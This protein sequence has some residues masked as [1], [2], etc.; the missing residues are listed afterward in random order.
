MHPQPLSCS[1]R[2]KALTQDV[3]YSRCQDAPVTT[4]TKAPADNTEC[5][6]VCS[7]AW[8]VVF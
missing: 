6:G 2:E 3:Q 8:M 1:L 5:G 7:L 4:H